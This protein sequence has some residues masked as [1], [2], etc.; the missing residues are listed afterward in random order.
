VRRLLGG[1]AVLL[2]VAVAHADDTDACIAAHESAQALRN[3]GHL[4]EARRTLLVCARDTCPRLVTNDCR[5]WLDAA[6]ADQPTV[7]LS[8]RDESGVETS[9]VRVSLDGALLT[10]HL[11]GRP[12]DVDPG[13]HVLRFERPR[14]PPVEQRVFL[15]AKEKERVVQA[16]FAPSTVVESRTLVET[17]AARSRWSAG[18]VVTGVIGILGLGAFGVLGI[19]GKVTESN[20][21]GS[22]CKP[23]CNASQI[24][25]IRNEYIAAY[26]SLGVGVLGL[27]TATVLLV[28]APTGDGHGAVASLTGRF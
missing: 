11:D 13:D 24:D 6:N 4:Q 28:A 17:H 10:S 16:S 5:P 18:A 19:T 21:A 2:S 1:L 8:V 26:V 15:R 3:Q 23:N 25:T 12:I 20:L 9:D 7:V 14:V 27:G 22:G